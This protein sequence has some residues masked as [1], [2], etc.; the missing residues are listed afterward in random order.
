MKGSL[1]GNTDELLY[2][3]TA[4]IGCKKHNIMNEFFICNYSLKSISDTF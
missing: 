4:T 2:A 1:K 3:E